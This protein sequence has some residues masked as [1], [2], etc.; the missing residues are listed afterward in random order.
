MKVLIVSDTHGRES[1][2]EKVMKQ[3]GPIDHLIHLGD[4]VGA[5]DYIRAMTDAPV[6]IVC[7]N[8]DYGSDLPYEEI[9][10]LDGYRALLTHGNNYYV[11]STLE[12]LKERAR[13]LEVDI[14]MYGHTHQP[15]LEQEEDLTI[16]NPGSLSLP[17]QDGHEPSY[18]LMETDRDGEAH[19][20]I[21]YLKRQLWPFA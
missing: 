10:D 13:E 14:V 9:V 12:Y 8:C 21:N 16:L 4:V 20:T 19:Y 5:E 18:I 7:G 6:S 17:R 3:V 1:N 11:G 15:Y 2:L